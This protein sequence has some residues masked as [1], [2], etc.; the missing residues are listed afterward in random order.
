MSF[1][2]S[3]HFGFIRII[4]RQR[5]FWLVRAGGSSHEKRLGL[6]ADAAITTAMVAI[7]I[8][9]HNDNNADASAVCG[10]YIQEQAM[11]D[12]SSGRPG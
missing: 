4:L 2:F 3:K 8:T 6:I 1:P 9:N 7:M 5:L 12:R 11:S 10:I